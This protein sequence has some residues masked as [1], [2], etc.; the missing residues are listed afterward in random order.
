MFLEEFFIQ[1]NEVEVI[2]ISTSFLIDLNFEY[3]LCKKN[4]DTYFVFSL[5]NSD[6]SFKIIL[7][8]F[9]GTYQAN[10]EKCIIDALEE[11]HRHYSRRISEKTRGSWVE[12]FE[13]QFK[14]YFKEGRKNHE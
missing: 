12:H 14:Q 9:Y 10:P 5:P 8:D 7:E 1:M 4:S 11:S 3:C 6:F 13:K 2:K